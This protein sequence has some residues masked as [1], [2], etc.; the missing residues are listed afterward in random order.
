MVSDITAGVP[1]VSNAEWGALCYDA[2]L[3][4]WGAGNELLVV[5]FTFKKGGAVVR[6]VADRPTPDR[7][8]VT[9][10]DNLSGLLTHRFMVHGKYESILE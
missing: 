2:E 5:R 1:V 9:V 3:K 4:S 10:N 8:V 6:L 7:L